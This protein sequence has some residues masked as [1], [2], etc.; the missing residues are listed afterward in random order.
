MFTQDFIVCDD[1]V[2]P[3]IIGRD[4]TVS[5]Y[6]SVIWM[7]QKTKKVTQDDRIAIK[8]EKP[9]RGKT[10][11]TT[12]RVAIPPRHFAKFELEC[13]MLEGKFKIQPEPFLQQRE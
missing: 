9:V 3:M 7:R 2:I 1:L 5:N 10:L 6:R 11:S 13:D 8:V 12:R 4:F